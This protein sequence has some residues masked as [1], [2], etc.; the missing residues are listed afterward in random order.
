METVK[1]KLMTSKEAA[2]Y[3]GISLSYFR[4]MMMRRVIPMYKPGGKLCF[5]DPKDLDDYLASSRVPSQA[6]ND[7]TAAKY[8][9]GKS[10]NLI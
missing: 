2:K 4:K 7:E 9:V 8:L 1:Q 6:E 5:F 10:L 3:L